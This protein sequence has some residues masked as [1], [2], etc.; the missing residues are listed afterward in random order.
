M[1]LGND[2]ALNQDQGDQNQGHCRPEPQAAPPAPSGPAGPLIQQLL[3]HQQGRQPQQQKA[4]KAHTQR[5][6]QDQHQP[7]KNQH[8][9]SSR[10]SAG[11]SAAPIGCYLRHRGVLSPLPPH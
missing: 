7:H 10:H 5:P 9:R 6:D 8:C 4:G 2:N 1:S 11:Q 3:Q